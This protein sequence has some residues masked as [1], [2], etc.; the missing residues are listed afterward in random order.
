MLKCLCCVD[1]NLGIFYE[2]ADKRFTE[3]FLCSPEICWT[4]VKI[5]KYPVPCRFFFRRLKNL[6]IAPNK[7]GICL[8]LLDR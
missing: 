1:I 6:F 4:S 2:T 5:Y 8:T 7:N 3:P